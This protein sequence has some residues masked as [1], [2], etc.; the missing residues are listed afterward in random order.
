MTAMR[1]LQHKIETDLS[2]L[3]AH[4]FTVDRWPAVSF[5]GPKGWE[6][7]RRRKPLT[8]QHQKLLR[9]RATLA[10]AVGAERYLSTG[11]ASSEFGKTDP[12]TQ[13]VGMT[14]EVFDC[15]N[16]EIEEGRG[17]LP[18]DMD[19]AHYVCVLGQ[20]LAKKLFP[21]ISAPGQ[22]VKL[23]GINYSVIGVLKSTSSM[24]GQ[25]QDNLVAVPITTAIN[26]YTSWSSLTLYVQA[27][28]QAA[29]DDTVEQVRGLLRAAR[30]VPPGGEDDFEIFSN[31]S[32]IQMFRK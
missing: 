14:P 31:D 30:R 8:M 11:E 5:E 15:K 27:R 12:D 13:L 22:K 9:Q 17:F 28:D 25:E 19:N 3:G 26:P 24:G 23:N 10:A 7:Y 2:G 6:K 18:V 29:Y 4:T 1:V 16:W 21:R 32:L 20:K